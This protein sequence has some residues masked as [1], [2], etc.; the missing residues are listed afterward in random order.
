MGLFNKLSEWN[1]SRQEKYVSTMRE[2]GRCPQC[3]GLG[4][5]GYSAYEFSYYNNNLDCTGCN[6]TGMY[7][8]WD[9]LR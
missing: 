5:Y 4:I 1:A 3:G 2:K 7:T 8:K 6:G 9:E